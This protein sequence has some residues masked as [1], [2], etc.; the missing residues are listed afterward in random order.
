MHIELERYSP[1][2]SL[3][4]FTA[5]TFLKKLFQTIHAHIT[6]KTELLARR[7]KI[8]NKLDIYSNCDQYPRRMLLFSTLGILET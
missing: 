3:L 8:E 5:Y 2:I 7:K 6:E 4:F 1:G